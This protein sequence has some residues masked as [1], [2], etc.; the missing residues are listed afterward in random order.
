MRELHSIGV[1]LNQIAARAHTIGFIDVDEYHRNAQE[2]NRIT[3][4]I[5]EAVVL[6]DK[7]PPSGSG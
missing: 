3:Q 5:Y 4:E 6:P 2:L 7:L 1:L